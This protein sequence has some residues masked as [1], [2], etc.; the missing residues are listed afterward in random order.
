MNPP[1][2]QA[3]D[4]LD[5][6]IATP[7][8]CSALEAARVQP[9]PATAPAHD[10][11]TRLLHRLEPDP[12]TLWL[13]AQT[14][15]CR[16]EGFLVLDDSTLDKPYARQIE[17]V[18]RHWSGKH[19][20]VVRGINLLTVLWTDGDRHLPCDYRLY[21]KARDGL[22]K[23]DLFRAMLQVAQERGFTPQ[24]VVFDGWYSSLENLKAI[25]GYGWLW[26]TRLKSNRGVNLDRQ[27]VR[28]VAEV[29]IAATGTEVYLP[30][31]GLVRVFRIVAPDG[32]TTHWATNDLT[33]TALR[34]LQIAEAS[35]KIEEYHRG[36]KQFCGVERAQIRAARA[37]RNHIGLALR[38]F[39]R[40][41]YHCFTTGISWFEAKTAII[42]DAVRA[43]LAQPW[44]KLPA[45]A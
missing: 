6:L 2:C 19:H 22:T 9:D 27:G 30:G 43:Y 12:Q 10:A 25:R 20:A 1:K 28:P 24:C 33:M 35:W 13:E 42:R 45:N 29:A 11:F 7:K 32:S 4:Y 26:L 15:V 18:T 44:Y 38:A 39:L 31:Y 41:E 21:D 23:N 8:V 34:R 17:L 16:T 36:I 3:S 5:F 40:L 14:Q 37:Q